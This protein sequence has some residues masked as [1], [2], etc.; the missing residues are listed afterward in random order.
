M[1]VTFLTNW[2][3]KPG[4]TLETIGHMATAKK[5]QTRLGADVRAFQVVVGGPAITQLAYRMEF[6]NAAAYG[7]CVQKLNADAE[8]QQFVQTVLDAADPAATLV[9]SSLSSTIP[10]LEPSG[11]TL[12]GAGPRVINATTLQVS[13]GRQQ[14]AIKALTELKPVLTAVGGRFSARTI[15]AGGPTTGQIAALT[16]HDDI[17]AFGVFIDKLATDAGWQKFL[18][19]WVNVPNPATTVVNR[20]VVSELAI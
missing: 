14:D 15:T 17:G 20:V 6:A 7:A 8:W 16:E 1:S 2:Q 19:T 18:T 9:N 13:L 3:P 11:P 10:G 5:I 12:S 4:R